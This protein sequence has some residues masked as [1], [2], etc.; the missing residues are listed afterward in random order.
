MKFQKQEECSIIITDLVATW[1]ALSSF[2]VPLSIHIPKPRNL[3]SDFLS[4]LP[5]EPR[6]LLL[7]PEH[8]YPQ[9]SYGDCLQLPHYLMVW[10][11]WIINLLCRIRIG[12][13]TWRTGKNRVLEMLTIISILWRTKIQSFSLWNN[14]PISVVL[15][16][17]I[18]C[19]PLH[20]CQ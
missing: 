17:Q 14:L 3:S 9:L 6:V 11:S 1:F 13:N 15:P 12:L 7:P 5:W 18:K 19:K 16:S 8:L 20:L 10:D 2:E 4:I